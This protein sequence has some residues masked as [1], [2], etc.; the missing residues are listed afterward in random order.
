MGLATFRSSGAR[1]I[2][3][4]L[5]FY[6]HFVPTGTRSCAERRHLHKSRQQNKKLSVCF[7]DSILKKKAFKAEGEEVITKPPFPALIVICLTCV[8]CGYFLGDLGALAVHHV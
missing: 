3:F 2:F 4:E 7:A 6:K 8:I 5:V 1:R